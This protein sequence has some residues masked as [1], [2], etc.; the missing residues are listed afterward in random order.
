[1]ASAACPPTASVFYRIAP[2]LPARHTLSMSVSVLAEHEYRVWRD[3]AGAGRH[4]WRWEVRSRTSG[5]LMMKGVSIESE[6][7][8]KDDA[9]TTIKQLNFEREN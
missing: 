5:T 7:A 6:S 1:M 8:A 3:M 9:I 4:V 2:H